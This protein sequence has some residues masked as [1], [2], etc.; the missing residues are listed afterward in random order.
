MTDSLKRTYFPTML[1]CFAVSV[2][3]LGVGHALASLPRWSQVLL[4]AGAMVPLILYHVYVAK[5]SG[6]GDSAAIDSVYYYGFL[7]TVSALAFSALTVALVEGEA[8]RQQVLFSFGL[9]LGATGYA[10]FA[11]MHLLSRA[12]VDSEDEAHAIMNRYIE[13][14]GDLVNDVELAAMRFKSFSELLLSQ[15][16]EAH[17]TAVDR[18]QEAVVQSTQ[19]FEREIKASASSA[20]QSLAELRATLSDAEFVTERAAFATYL[21]QASRATKAFG[22]ALSEAAKGAEAAGVALSKS[23]A[24]VDGL[25]SNLE[26]V[27]AALAGLSGPEGSLTTASRN[28]ESAADRT[29]RAVAQSCI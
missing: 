24:T 22:G 16:S 12:A 10:V 15:S 3:L 8:Q 17:K 4:T 5:R 11:R 2:S 19:L 18:M 23:N 27:S 7:L 13:R 1:G 9:G 6:Y 25:T 14:T 26:G 20:Q 28:L 21:S 29:A